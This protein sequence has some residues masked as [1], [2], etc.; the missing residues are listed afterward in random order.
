MKTEDFITK[1][2]YLITSMLPTIFR[3]ISQMSNEDRRLTIKCI[4]ENN[5]FGWFSEAFKQGIENYIKLE[6]DAFSEIPEIEKEI[7]S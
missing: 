6:E 7:T 5:P 1:W 2:D 4:E 3:D